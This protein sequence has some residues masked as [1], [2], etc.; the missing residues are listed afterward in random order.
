MIR[1]HAVP[2]IVSAVLALTMLVGIPVANAVNRGTTVST[3]HHSALMAS[4]VPTPTAST[5]SNPSA[6]G[7]GG[8]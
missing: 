6:G 5:N 2:L 1:K 8:G 3:T 7:N 4:D